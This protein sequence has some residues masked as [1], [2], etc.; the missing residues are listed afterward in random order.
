V[1]EKSKEGEYT[2]RVRIK[3]PV[4]KCVGKVCF[5]PDSNKLEVELQR[6]SCPSNV[7]KNIVENIVK[8]IEVEFVLPKEK[9]KE[10]K[11]E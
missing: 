11:K 5:N 6:D 10:S 9:P 8:G 2:E 7:I 1:A 3:S 4:G